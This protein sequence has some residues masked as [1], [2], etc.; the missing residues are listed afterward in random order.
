[1]LRTIGNILVEAGILMLRPKERSILFGKA[2][3]QGLKKKNPATL[4]LLATPTRMCL[5]PVRMN[6]AS[7]KI[8]DPH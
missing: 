6:V 3:G 1:M 4:Q 2:E 8:P 7:V 5:V